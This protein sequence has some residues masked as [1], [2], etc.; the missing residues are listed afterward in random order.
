MFLLI[1]KTLSKNSKRRQSPLLNFL[2]DSE[3][4]LA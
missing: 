1:G 2:K 4:Y 3:I